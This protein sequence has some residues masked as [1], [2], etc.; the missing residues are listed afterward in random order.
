MSQLATL[1]PILAGIQLL[2]MQDPQTGIYLQIAF[3]VSA[4]IVLIVLTVIGHK[5]NNMTYDP[6]VKVDVERVGEGVVRMNFQEHD[7]EEMKRV[8]TQIIMATVVVSFLNFQWNYVQPLFIQSVTGII[9]LGMS[10]LFRVHILGQE[11]TGGLA[12]PWKEQNVLLD[13]MKPQ[14][15][16]AT[17]PPPPETESSGAKKSKKASK[18]AD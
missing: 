15:T 12:R 10:P 11:A 16:T 7:Y 3:G 18:K 14:D 5:I 8:R 13:L 9:N 6:N 17:A 1:V 2:D 4:C